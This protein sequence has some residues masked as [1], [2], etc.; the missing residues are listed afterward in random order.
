MG[1]T[2]SRGSTAIGIALCSMLSL[3]AL[4][5][6]ANATPWT[7]CEAVIAKYPAGVAQSPQAAARWAAQGYERPVVS[8]RVF[9]QMRKLGVR[10]GVV[11]GETKTRLRVANA[12][13][14]SDLLATGT[15]SQLRAGGAMVAPGSPAN[16]YLEY[17]AATEE[18]LGWN[19]YASR[20]VIQP[21]PTPRSVV[22]EGSGPV[23]TYKIGAEP[24]DVYT[25]E[26]DSD[27]R[28]RS[29]TTPGGP[30]DR[31]IR[32][33]SGQASVV[34]VTI[35][36][37]LLYDSNSRTVVFVGS[38]SNASGSPVGVLSDAVYNSSQGRLPATTTRPCLL[39]GQT[40]PLYSSTQ[41]QGSGQI[42]ASWEFRLAADLG[43]CNMY[44]TETIVT[45]PI[46]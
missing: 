27:N 31:R 18:A 12:K 5:A 19:T 15:P 42:P 46:A 30:L 29:F 44:S 7:S 22:R 16:S 34:G 17:W 2:V 24:N 11:C 26:F 33:I 1:A 10:S 28:V 41:V 6:P 13:A 14:Y 21:P 8:K 43:E 40:A 9:S 20:G 25:F 23:I 32:N 38:A 4:A 3:G 36:A 37:N 39:P 45:V 35:Q